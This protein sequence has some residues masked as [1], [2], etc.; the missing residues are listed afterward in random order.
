MRTVVHLLVDFN[1]VANNEDFVFDVEFVRNCSK[2]DHAFAEAWTFQWAR[3]GFAAQ[4]LALPDG[5]EYRVEPA[6]GTE[7]LVLKADYPQSNQTFVLTELP[8]GGTKYLTA[9]VNYYSVKECP[10]PRRGSWPRPRH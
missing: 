6:N 9:Y 4:A 1:P 3:G 5:F 10:C 7:S 8:G 2:I